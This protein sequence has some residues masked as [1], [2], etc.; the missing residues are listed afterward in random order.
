MDAI[1]I[2]ALVA[3]W[4]TVGALFALKFCKVAGKC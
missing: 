2:V 1:Y 3:I 4:F